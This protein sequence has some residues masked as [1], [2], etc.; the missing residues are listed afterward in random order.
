MIRSK[1]FGSRGTAFAMAGLMLAL[2]LVALD[3]II[4]GTALCGLAWGM[5]ELIIFRGIQ[6]LGAGFIFSN[7]FT[8]IA[9]VFPDPARRAKYQGI[10]FGVFALSSVVGRAFVGR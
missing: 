10:F 8:S 6:G 5:T 7:I 3:Q 4:V 2:F 9:D 1:R